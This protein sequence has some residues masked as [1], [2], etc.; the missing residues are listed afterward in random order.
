M[1]ARQII[2]DENTTDHCYE[3]SESAATG[4]APEIVGAPTFDASEE[5][6]VHVSGHM[7]YP[8]LPVGFTKNVEAAHPP[9]MMPSSHIHEAIPLSKINEG[10]SRMTRDAGNNPPN[11]VGSAPFEFD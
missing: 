4:G 3:P 11:F 2:E 7:S 9:D 10:S 5:A 8:P 1:E 6:S